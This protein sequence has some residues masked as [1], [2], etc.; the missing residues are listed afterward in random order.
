[1]K[2]NNNHDGL[3][4]AYLL[5]GSGGAKKLTWKDI[6]G[7]HPKGSF[8]WLHF[9]YSR[10]PAREWITKKGNLNKLVA[11]ALLTEETRPRAT[12]FQDGL[13]LALRGVNLN[14]GSD[15]EDMVA[16]RVWMEPSRIISTRRRDLLSIDDLVEDIE[17]GPCPTTPG[18]FL[19]D[20]CDTLTIRMSHVIEDVEETADQLE[21]KVM[22]AKSHEL[23][24]ALASLRRQTITLRRYLAPQRE[25]MSHLQV[26]KVNWLTD[27]DRVRLREVS[28]RLIRHIE[29]LDA[30]RERAAV[31][32]EELISRLSEQLNSRMYILSLAAAIFL[33]L[34]FLTGLFGI[35]VGGIPGSEHP[36]AFPVFVGSLS[37]VAFGLIL[38]FK[39]KKWF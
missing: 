20:L 37:I 7:T 25:A 23:R 34:S 2:S 12:V 29:D 3:L 15:P 13:L 14:P 31:T 10:S 28:D 36:Y 4:H 22:E 32:H 17:K 27:A 16:I 1:M 21:E 26:E 35:N 18:E 30:I 33:P 24:M 39:K 19:V 11:K 5:D 9:D 38:L 6:G 8:L